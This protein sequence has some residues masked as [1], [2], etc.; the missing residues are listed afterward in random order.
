MVQINIHRALY[1]PNDLVFFNNQV[2]IEQLHRI[3]IQCHR[4]AQD[5]NLHL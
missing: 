5:R 1:E 3:G 2:F 4:S